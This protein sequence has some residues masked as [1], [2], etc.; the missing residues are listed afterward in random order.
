MEKSFALAVRV[1]LGVTFL[2]SATAKFISPLAFRNSLT[3]FGLLPP[4]S[5]PVFTYL[6]P[7]IELLVALALLLRVQV[8]R[9]AFFS[10]VLLVIFIAAAASAAISGAVVENCGCFGTSRFQARPE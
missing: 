4:T 3:S 7:L 6:I 5:V 10:A 8:K 2:V 1:V 9:T